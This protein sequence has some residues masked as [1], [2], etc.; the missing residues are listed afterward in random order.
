[1]KSVNV[2]WRTNSNPKSCIYPGSVFSFAW[3]KRTL[4]KVEQVS[5]WHT[6]RETF[7]SEYIRYHKKHLT[8]NKLDTRKT[9]ILLAIKHEGKMLATRI[10]EDDVE[11]KRSL[12]ILHV[13]EGALG[14]S[15]SQ[16][17]KVADA[18]TLD[19]NNMTCYLF[20]GSAKWIQSLPLMSLYAL[21]LRLGRL[22][23]SVMFKS[24]ED[25]KAF[26]SAVQKNKRNYG[27]RQESSDCIK[28]IEIGK[29]VPTVLKHVDDLFFFRKAAENFKE[30]TSSIQGI[31]QFVTNHCGEE[32]MK[33]WAKAKKKG[34]L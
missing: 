34:L 10:N 27:A 21:M 5:P 25:W 29:H 11:R 23:E 17:H 3:A 2:S 15:L 28:L 16:L 9:R 18:K 1:M 4:G 32:F 20:E 6:C 24:M 14:W 22:N 8:T 30:C 26:V 33:R 19:D 31:Q 7:G 13:V 12:R